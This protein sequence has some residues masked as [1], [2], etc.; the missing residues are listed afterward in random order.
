MKA[1][2]QNIKK[3]LANPGRP[4][5]NEDIWN[6]TA[7][8]EYQPY[9]YS[10][11]VA[12]REAWNIAEGQSQW[13]L[14]VINP[15]LVMGPAIGGMPTSESFN[16]MRQV[17]EGAFK[18]G[19]PKLGLGVVDVRD[20]AKAHLAA[21]FTPNAAGRY[22]TVAHD[23]DMF[24]ALNKLQ[25]KY[26]KDWGIPKGA[27]PKF[28]IWLIG[29]FVGLPRK[30]VSRTVNHEWKS[31]NSKSIQELGMSYRPMKETMEDMFQYMIDA[32]YFIKA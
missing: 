26:G 15:C 6:T 12:E 1:T 13:D 19:A 20:V 30:F 24:E 18:S 9:S 4:H 7:S 2:D 14:V 25:E 11:T 28:L 29:P 22:V 23:T 8:L 10:K 16:I 21:A 31:D 27:A 5:M 3:C 17:G 32:G